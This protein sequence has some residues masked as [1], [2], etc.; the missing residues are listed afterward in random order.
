MQL[1]HS[2]CNREGLCWV[3][4]FMIAGR[5]YTID[6]LYASWTND[7]T[8][9]T[10]QQLACSFLGPKLVLQ[11]MDARSRQHSKAVALYCWKTSIFR[12]PLKQIPKSVVLWHIPQISMHKQQYYIIVLWWSQGAWKLILDQKLVNLDTNLH[13]SEQI[14]SSPSKDTERE[15]SSRKTAVHNIFQNKN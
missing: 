2:S 7:A 15:H 5:K 12:T 4:S 14:R 13:L 3:V 10:N 1:W 11:L 9:Q 8:K 6:I